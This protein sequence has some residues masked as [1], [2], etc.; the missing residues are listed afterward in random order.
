M[1][2][3]DKLK[4]YNESKKIDNLIKAGVLAKRRIGFNDI[5]YFETQNLMERFLKNNQQKA[6]PEG[7]IN[8]GQEVE[9]AR[10]KFVNTIKVTKD[11]SEEQKENQGTLEKHEG[12]K[13]QKKEDDEIEISL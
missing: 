10:Q 6:L 3:I 11:R 12:E 13:E 7:T 9:N 8:R 2:K 1:N 4:L 5:I